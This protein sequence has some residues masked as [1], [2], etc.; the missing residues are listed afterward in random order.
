MYKRAEAVK[1]GEMWFS[2]Q[3]GSVVQW[4]RNAAVGFNSVLHEAVSF[5]GVSLVVYFSGVV[6]AVQFC[7]SE[8]YPN[9]FKQTKFVVRVRFVAEFVIEFNSAGS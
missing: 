3:R 5:S 8:H 9:K 1:C 6:L 2:L 4:R 7:V